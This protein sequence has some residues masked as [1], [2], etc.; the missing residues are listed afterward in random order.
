MK[1]TAAGLMAVH[2][3]FKGLGYGHKMMV[4]NQNYEKEDAP[5][6]ICRFALVTIELRVFIRNWD[7][8]MTKHSAWENDLKNIITKIKFMIL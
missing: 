5:K 3:N 4:S 7:L 6:S 1:G 8:K 2:P